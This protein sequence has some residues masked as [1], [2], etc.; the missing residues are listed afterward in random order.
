M[1]R[2]TQL[3][4]RVFQVRQICTD[5]ISNSDR[6]QFHPTDLFSVTMAFQSNKG[7]ET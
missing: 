6:F 1:V 2:L 4:K 3:G 7:S 5:G